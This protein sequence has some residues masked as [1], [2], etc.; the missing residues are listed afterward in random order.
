MA[1]SITSQGMSQ[2]AAPATISASALDKSSVTP[3]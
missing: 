3:E 2:G 1:E